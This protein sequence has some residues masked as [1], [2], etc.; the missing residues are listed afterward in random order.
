MYQAGNGTLI[1]Q[2]TFDALTDATIISN[3]TTL[4]AQYLHADAAAGLGGSGAL[5]MDWV[6]LGNCQD[7]SRLVE[8]GLPGTREI[9]VQFSMR[10]SSGFI[11]DW[12]DSGQSPCT[13]NAKKL[14][15]LWSGNNDSRF[16]FISENHT[17]G[18]GSDE[19]HPLFQQTAGPA[20]SIAQWG[21]GNW[22]RV[23]FHVLQSSTPTTADGF[24]YG[25]IDGVLRW[26][27]P[28]WV[29]HS[30]GGWTD[31]KLPT[32]FNQGSPVAQSEWLDNL[33]I[34]HP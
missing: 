16:D 29:S 6:P 25:W 27:V 28:N 31:F 13:G 30:S 4:Q 21:D 17:L 14:F 18:V 15:F 8:R 20:V 5:R 32:T 1:W 26:S 23:T 7:E 34:W 33:T 22:H 9:Y 3:Y 2:D 19:D 12:T 10:Y 11:F 24:I